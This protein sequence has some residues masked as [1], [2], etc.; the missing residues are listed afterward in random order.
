MINVY[1]SGVYQ[2]LSPLGRNSPLDVQALRE[3]LRK[4]PDKEL[5]RFWKVVRLHLFARAQLRQARP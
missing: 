5:F 2:D 1:G 4:M 3:R